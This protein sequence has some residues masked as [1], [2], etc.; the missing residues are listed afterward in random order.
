MCDGY[1]GSIRCVPIV[2][3]SESSLTLYRYTDMRFAAAGDMW[4]M[5]Q[6]SW[7]NTCYSI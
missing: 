7:F 6:N 4:L 3:T 1:N 5:G 2:D